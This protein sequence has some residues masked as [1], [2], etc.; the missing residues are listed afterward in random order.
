MGSWMREWNDPN[1]M[2]HG[3]YVI[4]TVPFGSAA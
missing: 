2:A 3:T 1:A 4:V